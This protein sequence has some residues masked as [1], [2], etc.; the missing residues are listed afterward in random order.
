MSRG[1]DTAPGR[2][3]TGPA[4]G[5][6][7]SAVLEGG[8][9]RSIIDQIIDLENQI[10]EMRKEC[11]RKKEEYVEDADELELKLRDSEAK[12]TEIKTVE[13]LFAVARAAQGDNFDEDDFADLC[14]QNGIG[15]HGDLEADIDLYTNGDE[16]DESVFIE[17]YGVDIRLAQSLGTRTFTPSSH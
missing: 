8:A 15:D 2:R 13:V 14:L 10:A 12:I 4:N 1:E 6:Q 17:L 3:H 11:D 7:A 9:A 5:T 16:A